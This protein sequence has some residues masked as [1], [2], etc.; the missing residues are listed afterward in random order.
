MS[1]SL[2]ILEETVKVHAAALT[3]YARQFFVDGSFHSAEEVVQ[4]VFHRLSRQPGMPENLTA[5]LY[6]AVRT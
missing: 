1:I 4:E 5:W 6:A 2:T 3:L